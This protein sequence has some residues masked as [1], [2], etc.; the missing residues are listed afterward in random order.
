MTT[1]E[2]SYWKIPYIILTVKIHEILTESV[3]NK[4]LTFLSKRSHVFMNI[5]L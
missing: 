2:K 1:Q 3:K 5:N 4:T